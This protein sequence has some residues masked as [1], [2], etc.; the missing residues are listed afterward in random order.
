MNLKF[1][2]IE[3]GHL[4]VI[5]NWRNGLEVS[6]YM[7]SNDFI[8][9]NKQKEWFKEIKENPTKKAWIIKMDGEYIGIV[10]IY[11][12]DERNKR[13]YWAYYIADLSMRG[14][15][16]GRLIELNIL[17]YVFEV[18]ELNKLCAT[19]LSFN[20]IVVQIHK[21][22]GS[23]VEGYFRKH[24]FKDGRFLDVVCMGIL[25]KD[26]ENIKKSFDFEV[27]KIEGA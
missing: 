3:V 9:F 14:R 6:K 23:K 19:V 15:G 25:K 12:I 5:R 7:Y 22:Y 27:I 10:N 21:K 24:V 2:R 8:T 4:E 13:C 18:L 20:Q 26:W 1:C 16:I 17:R 11:D